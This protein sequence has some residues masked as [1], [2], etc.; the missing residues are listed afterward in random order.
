MLL[1]EL[2][3]AATGRETAPGGEE[4][5]TLAALVKSDVSVAEGYVVRLGSERPEERLG[6]AIEGALAQG[7]VVRLRPLFPS[8]AVA[9]RLTRALGPLPDL[10]QG[11]WGG[12]LRDL[13]DALRSS[14]LREV[15]D[16]ELEAL[17]VRVIPADAS[18]AG[19]AA[20]ADPH[21]GDPDEV[22]VWSRDA[23]GAPWRVDR[24][25]T[26]VAEAGD[27]LSVV[28]AESAADLAD[29][30][31]LALG[32]PVE[33][34]WCTQDTRVRLLTVRPLTLQPK[35]AEGS[36]RRLA[37]VAADEGT[38]APL[39]IDALDRALGASKGAPSVEVSVRRIYARPY[40]RRERATLLGRSKSASLGRAAAAAARATAEAAPLLSDASKFER[41]YPPI[42]A[43]LDAV[44]LRAEGNVALIECLRERH[45]IVADAFLLLDRAREQTRRVLEALECAAGP[46][47]RE[48]YG[49]LAAPHVVESRRVIHDRLLTLADRAQNQPYGLLSPTVREEWDRAREDLATI[50][51][52]GIDVTPEPIGSSDAALVEAFDFLPRARA[53][54]TARAAA[55]AR[56]LELARTQSLGLPR[57]ALARSLGAL[58]DGVARA[59]G[60]ISEG[61]AAALLRL[62]RAALEVGRRLEDEAI[63]DAPVDAL[64]LGL[65]EL[66]EA[67]GGEPGA[68]AARVRLRRE[69]DARWA[70]F[71]A[72]RRLGQ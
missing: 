36:W 59:K 6:A 26:R 61:L 30:A 8:R 32:Y 16:T 5:R 38:V 45:R 11:D 25:S 70:N 69:D 48:T 51:P 21:R 50:R 4:A 9:M 17:H 64:Y 42:I 10:R 62:R 47:P 29:R 1:R 68:Y 13:L 71:E 58:L 19:R 28:I 40:R 31:Q 44:D 15:L 3:D 33:V 2:T 52:L 35:F 7:E 49:A 66:T 55:I 67:L 54:E 72:P 14:E 56:V 57:V 18:P 20:S 12:P 27:G 41:A 24:R 43:S 23:A 34:E 60:G 37:L 63:L 46:L 53:R 22:S 39:A 65:D